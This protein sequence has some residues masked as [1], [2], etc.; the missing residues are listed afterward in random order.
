MQ[1]SS[2]GISISSIYLLNLV[3]FYCEI[4]LWKLKTVVLEKSF[5]LFNA[6][7]GNNIFNRIQLSWYKSLG[8]SEVV[9]QVYLKKKR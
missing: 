4:N 3:D 6:I 7:L 5:E 1:I 2:V 8:A 9:I